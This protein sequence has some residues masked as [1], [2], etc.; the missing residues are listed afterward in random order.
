MRELLQH[1]ACWCPKPLAVS[2]SAH[3]QWVDDSA[4]FA[5]RLA[6]SA[7]RLI[8]AL[9]EAPLAQLLDSL[10]PVVQDRLQLCVPEPAALR[11]RACSPYT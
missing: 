4:C 5:P 3:A 9:G 11:D 6:H 10:G 2:D 1:A 8:S 7:A